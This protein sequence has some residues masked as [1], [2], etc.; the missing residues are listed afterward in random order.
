MW[1]RSAAVRRCRPSAERAAAERGATNVPRLLKADAEVTADAERLDY[2]SRAG[3]AEFSGGK[4]ALRQEDTA[5]YGDR[6]VIDQTK[7]DLSATGNAVS[8]LMI[9]NKI[10]T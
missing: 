3:T 8:R 1:M 9:D 6:V 10:M 7:G 2:D 4:P 5:I